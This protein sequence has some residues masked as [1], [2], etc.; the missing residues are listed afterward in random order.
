MAIRLYWMGGNR[1]E[2]NFG[3]SMSP[4]I[5]EM[6]AGRPVR[7]AP[8]ENCD[9]IAMG[10]LLDKVEKKKLKR[11]LR[12]RFDPIR[13]WGSGAFCVEPVTR[14]GLA[15][16]AVRGHL[17]RQALQLPQ[18][19]S[20]GDPGLLVDRF[21]VRR[22]KEHRWGIVPHVADRNESLIHELRAANPGALLIDLGDPDLRETL[23]KIQSCEFIISSSLH[24]LVTADAFGI[25]SVWLRVSGNLYGGDGKFM[26]YFSAVGRT[27]N[28]PVRP[29][30]PFS[31][32][33]LEAGAGMA[34]PALVARRRVELAKAFQ[35]MG[36]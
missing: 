18:E 6:M 3:D 28:R 17:T 19:M 9:L 35:A 16:F 26:D 15:P 23:R 29:R 24:G 14:R 11:L 22:G 33:A 2:I 10:S 12:F 34:A 31:L 1:G 32:S 8:P 30:L 5:V 25:P 4:L 20:L 36:F 7:Y 21:D 13:V 27:E